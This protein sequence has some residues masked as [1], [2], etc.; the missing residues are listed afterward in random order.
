MF[1]RHALW[2]SAH[3]SQPLAQAARPRHE[4]IASLGDPITGRELEEQRAV[5]AARLLI[6]D[7]LDAGG[8]TEL[9]DPC[10]CFKLLLSARR[11]F[12]F[13]Q[14]PEP[15]GV[16]ETTRFGLVFEFPESFGQAMKTE[17]VQLVE[18]RMSEHGDFPLNGSSRDHADW[19]DPRSGARRPSLAAA[20]SGLRARRAATPLQLKTPSSRARAE[21]A[22]RRAVSR[23]RYERRMPRQVRNP[24]SGCGRLAS[25]ALIRPSVLGP[26]LPAQRRNRSGVHSA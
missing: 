19:R 8:V 23:P 12:V 18:C 21:T 3:A 14:Q 4:K 25:T 1:S 9:G 5:E 2:P 17:G 22:S 6:V 11:Q 10:P 16:I 20:S 7:V 24:C 26:I 13:E 15:F